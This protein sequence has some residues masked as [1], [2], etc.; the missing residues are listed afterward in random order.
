MDIYRQ[1]KD[2]THV[3]NLQGKLEPLTMK[4]EHFFQSNNL[5]KPGPWVTTPEHAL[6]YVSD[7]LELRGELFSISANKISSFSWFLSKI[8]EFENIQALQGE[9]K[10]PLLKY[11]R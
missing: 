10:I 4:V 8:S 1:R 3:E 6:S 5:I 7:H 2:M 9:M 11:Y